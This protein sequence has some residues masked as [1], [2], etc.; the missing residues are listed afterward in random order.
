MS[1]FFTG[2]PERDGHPFPAQL[3]VAT[4]AVALLLLGALAGA[5]FE[6]ALM[7]PRWNAGPSHRGFQRATFMA[8]AVG[9]R[10]L[11]DRLAGQ[12]E[13]TPAQRARIDSIMAR[14]LRD[15]EQVRQ[16]VRPRMRE[17]YASTRAEMDSVLTPD[18]RARLHT[19]FP[20]RRMGPG[21]WARGGGRRGHGAIGA[22]RP[23]G[24]QQ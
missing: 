19:L 12:L 4:A 18:Q 14:N 22:R 24:R 20:R 23:P 10:H 2:R 3:F 11:D 9:P 21:P 15:I 13:L 5:T 17:I 6:R 7:R 16:Q 1:S 8:T